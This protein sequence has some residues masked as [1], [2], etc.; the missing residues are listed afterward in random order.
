[1]TSFDHP[2]C[3][4][5]CHTPQRLAELRRAISLTDGVTPI[6]KALADETRVKIIYAL[7]QEPDLCVC[8]V[9]LITSLTA[10]A[11]SH[12]LRLLKNMGLARSRREGKSVHYS[13]SDEHVRLILEKALE[14]S[15]H[16]RA[17]QPRAY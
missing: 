16:L 2:A 1:M 10:A 12:H 4:T 11:A 8:D 5:P 7:L 3:D 13:L 6:F 9:A 15:A 17:E 14:H